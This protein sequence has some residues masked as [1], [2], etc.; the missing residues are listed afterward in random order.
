M[1]LLD[2]CCYDD[3]DCSWSTTALDSGWDWEL[4]CED[5]DNARGGGNHGGAVSFFP[6][7]FPAMPMFAGP[8]SSPGSSSSS[9]GGGGYLEDA[10]AHWSDRCKRQRMTAAEEPLS[11]PRCSVL[12]AG[13]ELQCLLQSF[14]DRPSSSGGSGEAGSLL[15]DSNIMVPG[16]ET[17]SIAGS[18]EEEEDASGKEKEQ[19][20]VQGVP[21]SQAWGDAAA[22]G[23]P[24]AFSGTEER[25][26]RTLRLQKATT[27]GSHYCYNSST[28]SSGSEPSSSSCSKLAAGGF[29]L[30][31]P[32][33][34]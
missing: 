33:S 25:A 32:V 19:V 21:F 14:W 23:P 6:S 11:P 29:G 20:Q 16:P 4:R 18:G 30:G 27:G 7:S 2:S 3:G 5:D 8:E 24:P 9:G 26:V 34:N 13:E 31:A 28:S 12:T 22:G 1:A 17:R 10:V 15:H